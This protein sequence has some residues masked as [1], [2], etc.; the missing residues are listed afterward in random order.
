MYKSVADLPPGPGFSWPHTAALDARA[1]LKRSVVVRRHCRPWELS[2]L[3][4]G[5]A[6]EARAD[7]DRVSACGIRELRKAIAW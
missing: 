7:E 4:T 3:Y 2:E 1:Y 5:R 6:V